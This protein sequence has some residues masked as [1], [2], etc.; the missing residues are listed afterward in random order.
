MR[1]TRYGLA[2]LAVVGLAAGCGTSGNAATTAEKK[3]AGKSLEVVATWTGTEKDNFGLVLQAYEARTG[4]TV[5]YTSGGNNVGEVLAAKLTGG[6]PPNVAMI[7]QPGVVADFYAKGQVKPVTDAAL[8]AVK[9]NYSDAWQKLGQIDGTQVGFYWKAANKS[10]VWYD[11]KS[12]ETA[13][14]TEPRT[15]EDFVKVSQTLADAG[16]SP[17]TVPGADGWTLTDWFEN[18]YLRVAGPQKYDALF[19]H[20]MSWD[21]PSVV[22]TLTLLGDY[23]KNPNFVYKGS[24]ATQEKFDASVLDVFGPHP[25]SAMLFEGDFV[26]ALIDAKGS[27]KVGSGAKYFPFPSIKGSKSSVVTGG[28]EVV[29]LKDDAVTKDFVAYLASPEAARLQA[30]KGGFLS[31]N[32]GVDAGAYP[33]DTTR[34][35]AKDITSADVLRFDGSDLSPLAFGGSDSADMWVLLQ[36]FLKNPS[37]PAG[38]AKKLEAAAAKDFK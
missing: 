24:N 35:L 11:T 2:A 19:S 18:V 16:I 12:F 37:D 26:G 27:V 22:E 34:A 20:K 28:D 7:A 3:F 17:M 14:I 38:T 32:K 8:T 23:W 1:K 10:T 4:A 13:G 33:D 31:P 25:T 15:W 9:A 30:R 29:A 5:T 6:Q 21:D 36:G